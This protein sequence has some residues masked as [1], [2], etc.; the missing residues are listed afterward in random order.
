MQKITDQQVEFALAA[1]SKGNHPAHATLEERMRAALQSFV[2]SSEQEPMAPVTPAIVTDEMR[3]LVKA[4]DSNES[5]RKALVNN[6]ITAET[7]ATCAITRKTILKGVQVAESSHK[8]ARD[9]Y[10]APMG[11]LYCVNNAYHDVAI[12]DLGRVIAK[13]YFDQKVRDK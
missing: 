1:F 12:S 7:I 11:L 10:Y 2:Y 8:A 4:D 6:A 9:F 13:F 5:Q 3:Q